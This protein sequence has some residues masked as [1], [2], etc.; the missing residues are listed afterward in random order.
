[1][2]DGCE[3]QDRAWKFM[4][5]YVGDSCQ[6]DYSNEMAAILGPSAKHPTANISALESLPWTRAEYEQIK[7]QF[8][9]LASIPNYP[10][11]YIVGRYTKFAFL[12]AYND[13]QNP[14]ASLLGYIDYINDE[15]TRKREE[16]DLEALDKEAEQTTLA[17]RRMQQAEEALKK[18]K[19]DSRYSASYDAKLEEIF[20]EISGYST[21]DYDR[22]RE[23]A[24]DL[25]AL[26]SDLF[27]TG[28]RE[29]DIEKDAELEK[30]KIYKA[31]FYLVDAAKWLETYEAYKYA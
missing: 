18:A 1:M 14:V 4:K 20:K 26:N 19:E 12:D 7:Y 25:T 9:N 10:G 30:E 8:D 3:D 6:I 31:A 5:W 29:T 13:N 21:E 17:V 15:I 22:L 27:G 11:A 16:F 24:A 2:I 23:L 28:N